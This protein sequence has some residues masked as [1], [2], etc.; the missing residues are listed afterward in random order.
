MLMTI[1]TKT[2]PVPVDLLLAVTAPV[3]VSPL[4]EEHRA[5]VLE[6]LSQRPIH[7]VMMAGMIRDNGLISEH[8]RGT[9]YG[10]RTERGQLEGVALIGHATLLETRTDRALEALASQAQKYTR[11][12]LIMGEQQRMI[13][14]WTYYA[15]VGQQMRLACRELLLEL[16]PP[17]AAHEIKLELHTATASDLDLIIPV[18]AQMAF[19]E[20]GV[21]P[22][23][24]D[25]EGFRRRCL[26]RTELGRT[27][28]ATERGRL[29][30]KAEIVSD[31][32]EVNY[33]EGIYV[34][35]DARGKG[36]G[37]KYLSQLTRILFRRTVSV[38]ILVNEQNKA[39]QAFYRKAGFQFRCLYDTVFLSEGAA[40][41]H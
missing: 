14:F 8:H 20:S 16:K 6:F 12:H 38:C 31:L 29:L 4:G 34:A 1:T 41:I 40:V 13:E 18:Q 5:E 33:L 19:E 11:A 24:V 3:R 25:P 21:N 39:A 17:V 23:E 35:P 26:R 28:V 22:L 9:F 32:P 2:P 27:W 15:E 37:L 10:C 7:T 36:Y 30:F